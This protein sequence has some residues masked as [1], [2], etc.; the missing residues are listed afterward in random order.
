VDSLDIALWIAWTV[1]LYTLLWLN[2]ASDP[3]GHAIA[4]MGLASR[5]RALRRSR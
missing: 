3:V 1:G 4:G 2:T 5:D